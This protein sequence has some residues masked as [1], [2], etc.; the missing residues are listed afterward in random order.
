MTYQ[1]DDFFYGDADI[2]QA[3]LEAAGRQFSR[4]LRRVKAALAKGDVY[5]AMELCSHG[6]SGPS[7]GIGSE[8]Q[9]F[10]CGCSLR[11]D[12]P[13]PDSPFAYRE[14]HPVTP[15]KYSPKD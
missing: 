7:S 11:E 12:E 5:T 2:E 8:L 10:H 13:N 6:W 9:C 1:P 4:E 3:E 14:R 15:G